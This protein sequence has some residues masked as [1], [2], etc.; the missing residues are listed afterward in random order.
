[1]HGRPAKLKVQIIELHLPQ[2]RP[3]IALNTIAELIVI[4]LRLLEFDQRLPIHISLGQPSQRRIELQSHAQTSI[5]RP[6]IK[7]PIAHIADIAVKHQ[8]E[9][10]A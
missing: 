1:V 4:S 8:V 3:H 10:A 9:S 5:R 7:R 2:R 6:Q